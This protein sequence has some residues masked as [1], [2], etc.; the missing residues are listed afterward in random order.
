LPAALLALTPKCLLCVL[1]FAGLGAAVG[2]G[3]PEICGAPAGSPAAWATSLAWLG[4]ACG[5]ATFGFFASCRRARSGRGERRRA[6]GFVV[7]RSYFCHGFQRGT[8]RP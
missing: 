3:G 1:A 8:R 5:L 4:V 2:L 6:M 7:Y